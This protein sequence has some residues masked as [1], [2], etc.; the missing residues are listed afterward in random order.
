MTPGAAADVTGKVKVGMYIVA[1]NGIDVRNLPKPETG[2]LIRGAGDVVTLRLKG[3]V[4]GKGNARKRPGPIKPAS[5]LE[6]ASADLG[7]IKPRNARKPPRAQKVKSA[8]SFEV[9]SVDLRS[10][11]TREK[12]HPMV[13]LNRQ[14]ASLLS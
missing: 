11:K 10:A 2:G 3:Q 9:A 4:G 1:V 12:E 5:L 13:S 8:S 14:S 6:V 7:S